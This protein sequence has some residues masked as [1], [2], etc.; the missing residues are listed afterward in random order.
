MQLL[1]RF[2]RRQGWLLA[3]LALGAAGYAFLSLAPASFVQPAYGYGPCTQDSDCDQD[4][5]A[6]VCCEGE[7]K[8]PPS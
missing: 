5:G 8:T 7:C 6:Q 4:D 1:R 2:L 3:T